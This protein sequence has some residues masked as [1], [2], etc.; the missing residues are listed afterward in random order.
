MLRYPGKAA[1]TARLPV[2]GA[3][4][5][6]VEVIR[7]VAPTRSPVNAVV[8]TDPHGCKHVREEVRLGVE[9]ELRVDA[10]AQAKNAGVTRGYGRK[11]S[12]GVYV[13]PAQADRID[14]GT[15]QVP[16]AR[17][18][19][20]MPAGT[21][22][23]LKKRYFTHHGTKLS[24]RKLTLEA[25]T[26]EGRQASA[27]VQRLDVDHVRV[28]VGQ[29]DYIHRALKAGLGTSD[30]GV[31]LIRDQEVQNGTLRHLDIDVSTKPG[32]TA[33]Q[34]FLTTGDL[35]EPGTDTSSVGNWTQVR[36]ASYNSTS[37]IEAHGGPLTAAIPIGR[38]TNLQ[39]TESVGANGSL[40]HTLTY[41]KGHLTYVETHASDARGRTVGSE[42]GI[43]LQSVPKNWLDLYT[44]GVSRGRTEKTRS[45]YLSFTTDELR[46]MQQRAYKA[47][48]A[49]CRTYSATACK[50]DDPPTTPHQVRQYVHT[51][52]FAE[53]KQHLFGT[54]FEPF[55]ED[56]VYAK[57][58]DKVLATIYTMSHNPSDFLKNLEHFAVTTGLAIEGDKARD[59]G[60]HN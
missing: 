58:P 20:R 36:S 55:T 41:Q 2:A 59:N 45:V 17:L 4:P 22:I 11:R 39:V 38:A 54:E 29:A 15:T 43:L 8:R 53:A 56:I 28:I 25:D 6:G 19:H 26:A 42:Y 50:T 49:K 10:S 52:S 48:A 13:T 32:W 5:L 16:V 30:F 51:H 7:T 9:D 35:H 33:Y 1:F 37:S 18:P 31:S 3:G 24:Y 60:F 46:T 23:E 40:Q 12:Y 44:T 14:D 27:A 47:V 34:M 57:G 21:T